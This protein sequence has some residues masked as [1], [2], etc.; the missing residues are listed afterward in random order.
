MEQI[1]YAQRPL[2]GTIRQLR[3]SD[4]PRFAE[5]LLR[6]DSQSR[7]DRFN[8]L[9][10]DDFLRA[11]AERCFHEGV[12]VIGY[13]EGDKVLGA[14]ELHEQPEEIEPTA[15]IAFSVESKLQHRGIGAR[16][17]RRLIAQARGLGYQH[18]QVTT[19]SSNLA[20]KALARRF[21]ARLSFEQGDAFGVIDLDTADVELDFA[22]PSDF[23]RGNAGKA[24]AA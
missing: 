15:E 4:L 20:M 21:N 17:F 19:H 6:L 12:T 24:M 18:L 22:A 10:D 14:A 13:V 9:A 23:A 2:V 7:R 8:G 3:P 11:Y 5:H 16:L 1:I